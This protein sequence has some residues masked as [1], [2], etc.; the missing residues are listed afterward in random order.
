MGE[1]L[2]VL[3]DRGRAPDVLDGIDRQR[4]A[5]GLRAIDSLSA[6]CEAQRAR[7]TAVL[8]V[9]CEAPEVVVAEVSR[10]STR[11]A[12]RLVDRAATLGTM[13]RFADALADGQ[14]AAGH[15][16]AL[17]RGLA[18]LDNDAQRARL[19][20]VAGQLEQAAKV[21][22]PDDFAK[23]VRRE[24]QRIQVADGDDPQARLARQR[25][26]ARLRSWV[27]RESGMWCLAGRFD[28]LTGFTIHNQLQDTV[29]AL[30]RERQPADAPVDPGERQDHLRALAFVQLMASLAESEPQAPPVRLRRHG[31][32]S[33]VVVIDTAQLQ[34]DGTPSVDWGIPIEVPL[35]VLAQ[36][37]GQRVDY[38]VVLVCNGIVL[39]APGVLN[40]G[41]STR[42]ANRAQRRALHALYR[43]CAVPGCTVDYRCCKLHHINWWRYGGHTDLDNLIPLCERH[44]H[45]VH[46]RGWTIALGARRELTIHLPDGTTLS[47]GP[48]TRNGP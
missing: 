42:I 1:R 2:T 8:A 28:P 29:N 18:S 41:R 15:V 44:H 30:F 9:E 11:E 6:W 13:P 32:V 23:R 4:A 37:A 43:T 19:A 46:D 34:S 5:D 38:Q 20:E 31:S 39:H 48:P 24:V 10:C 27:D 35:P 40:L 12:D 17:T 33:G 21:M 25:K 26:A 16:D 47:A 3:I 36:L 7:W 45:A 22:T 14:I